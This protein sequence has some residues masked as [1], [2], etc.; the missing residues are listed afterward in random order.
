MY[1]AHKPFKHSFINQLYLLNLL[2]SNLY[3]NLVYK[4]KINLKM[5]YPEGFQILRFYDPTIEPVNLCNVLL[6]CNH[7][8]FNVVYYPWLELD[9]AGCMVQDS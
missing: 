3:V 6:L 4:N 8:W 7:A 5:D 1:F 2:R 9:G